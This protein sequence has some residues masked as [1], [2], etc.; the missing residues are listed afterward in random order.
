MSSHIFREGHEGQNLRLSIPVLFRFQHFIKMRFPAAATAGQQRRQMDG[1]CFSFRFVWSH[2]CLFYFNL[3]FSSS[4]GLMSWFM[5][6]TSIYLIRK[7]WRLVSQFN[8]PSSLV[9]IFVL[10]FVDVAWKI[11]IPRISQEDHTAPKE[12]HTENHYKEYEFVLAVFRHCS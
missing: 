7:R 10:R 5:Y 3:L 4:E 6:I 2:L 11:V 1:A 9:H 8:S 12:H